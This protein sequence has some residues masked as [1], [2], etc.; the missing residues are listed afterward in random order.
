MRLEQGRDAL[1]SGFIPCPVLDTW[2]SVRIVLYVTAQVKDRATATTTQQD[3]LTLL[4][5]PEG[6]E[7]CADPRI[8]LI[9]T[10]LPEMATSLEHDEIDRRGG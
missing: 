2:T 8:E 4:W 9:G 3:I 7:E 1:D 5:C 6:A 10:L